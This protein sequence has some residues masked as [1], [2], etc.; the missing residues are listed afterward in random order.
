MN[1]FELYE[2]RRVRHLCVSER[3][4]E[5]HIHH[6]Y[7]HQNPYVRLLIA[8]Y[9]NTGVEILKILSQD[10]FKPVRNGVARNENCTEELLQEIVN[11]TDATLMA[12]LKNPN[13]PVGLLVENSKSNNFNA[14]D[15]VSQH[16]KTPVEVLQEYLKH[17]DGD[18]RY[19]ARRNLEKR[20]IFN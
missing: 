20:G 16:P 4:T 12:V 13:C 3:L 17:N 5:E 8:E 15:A 7:K 9:Q 14:L 2:E 1:L 19:Y 10:I 18:V 11:N 6:Y